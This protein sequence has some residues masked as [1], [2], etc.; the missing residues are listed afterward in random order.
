[1]SS[2]NA[3]KG[4]KPRPFSVTQDQFDSLW[5]YTFGTPEERAEYAAE[6]A[7]G[8]FWE[9]HPWATG[10]WDEDKHRWR[11][12]RLTRYMEITGEYGDKDDTPQ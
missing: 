9:W 7:S 11:A 1:M 12:A 8:M 2:R 3:G 10:K 6:I 4:S 5:E